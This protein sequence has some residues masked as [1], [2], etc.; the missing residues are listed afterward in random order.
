M[1]V[2]GQMS[3]YDFIYIT[4]IIYPKNKGV[5]PCSKA[6]LLLPS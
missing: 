2:A 5:R 4:I 3:C 6:T 1:Q